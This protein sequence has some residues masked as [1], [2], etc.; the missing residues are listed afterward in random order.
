MDR[1]FQNDKQWITYLAFLY[2]KNSFTNWNFF[3][4]YNTKQKKNTEIEQRMPPGGHIMYYGDFI[5]K[6]LPP[7]IFVYKQTNKHTHGWLL[8]IVM[9]IQ[10]NTV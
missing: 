2:G 3:F 1:N 5:K 7:N 4:V 6:F 9:M 10:T 8:M